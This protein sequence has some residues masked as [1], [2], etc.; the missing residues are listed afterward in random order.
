MVAFPCL[1]MVSCCI[2]INFKVWN[3]KKP[4]KLSDITNVSCAQLTNSIIIN[5]PLVLHV[6]KV[7]SCLRPPIYAFS[8]LHVLLQIH[9]HTF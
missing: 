6:F 2:R 1:L 5:L 9:L 7:A 4:S 8:W 3:N